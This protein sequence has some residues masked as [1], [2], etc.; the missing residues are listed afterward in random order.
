MKRLKRLFLL[1]AMLLVL[2]TS[3]VFADAAILPA[4]LFVGGVFI[5]IVA[6]VIVALVLLFKALKRRKAKEKENE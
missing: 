1:A 3:P 5:L 6:V 4:F 2:T